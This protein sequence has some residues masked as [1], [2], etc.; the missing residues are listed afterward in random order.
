[1]HLLY[2]YLVFILQS[3]TV[4]GKDKKQTFFQVVFKVMA[5]LAMKNNLKN[6]NNNLVRV[7]HFYFFIG[8]LFVISVLLL[9]FNESGEINELLATNTMLITYKY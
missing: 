8:F 6:K 3:L 1:M 2:I 5:Q 9:Y 7:Y 4:E